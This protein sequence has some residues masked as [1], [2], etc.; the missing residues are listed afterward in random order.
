[1]FAVILQGIFSNLGNLSLTDGLH[2]KI[3]AHALKKSLHFL[4]FVVWNPK[5]TFVCLFTSTCHLKQKAGRLV[6]M[7]SPLLPDFIFGL[8]WR[9]AVVFAGWQEVQLH[10]ALPPPHGTL[11]VSST[12]LPGPR[13]LP[14]EQEPCQLWAVQTELLPSATIIYSYT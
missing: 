12:A 11:G 1:M 6:W 13:N 9:M 10:R 8:E 2:I 5:C 4:L 14:S 3:L 7:S